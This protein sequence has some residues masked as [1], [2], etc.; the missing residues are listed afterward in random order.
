[1]AQTALAC[2]AVYL[3]LAFGVRTALQLRRTGSTG[4][5][6]V[7][8]RPGSAEWLAGVLFVLALIAGVAAP[9]LDL[10]GLL[11]PVA[12]LDGSVGHFAGAVLFA[13]G[14]AATLWAQIAMG[15]SWRVGV[16]PGERTELVTDGPFAL[17][18]NPIFAGMLPTSLGLVLL[19]PN[20]AALVGLLA[21]LLALEIQVRV[22]EEPYLLRSHGRAYADYAG[23]VGRFLPGLGR[24]DHRSGSY[25]Q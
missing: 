8:G 13:L 17:V 15:D 4:F 21:L 22:V 6:G 9:L 12:P 18:R 25:N 19:V 24:L 10:T 20:V 11:E 23:R 7:S 14:L 5:H 16:D 3:A 2:F 1:M